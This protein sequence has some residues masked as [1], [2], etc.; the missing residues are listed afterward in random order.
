MALVEEGNLLIHLGD[1]GPVVQGHRTTG[2]TAT[3]RTGTT[4]ATTASGERDHEHQRQAHESKQA[5]HP[6]R[7][8][9]M[10]HSLSAPLYVLE[11]RIH[12]SS[13]DCTSCPIYKSLPTI[14]GSQKGYDSKGKL[15]S[16]LA[17]LYT[18]SVTH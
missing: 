3:P 1:P 9:E 15:E 6:L 14:L 18:V 4:T 7:R 2:G 16:S 8:R 17:P 10:L 11:T 13:R 12:T 5:M